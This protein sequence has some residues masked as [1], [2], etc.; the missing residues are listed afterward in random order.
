MAKM[1]IFSLILLIIS[2]FFFSLS[3]SQ[4]V[5]LNC[6]LRK[7][8]GTIKLVELDEY[9]P[10]LQSHTLSQ[11]SGVMTF[12]TKTPIEGITSSNF[13]NNGS[14][15]KWSYEAIV[16]SLTSSD[17]GILTY[18]FNPKNGRTSLSITTQGVLVLGPLKGFC[19]KN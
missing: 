9:T 2:F 16:D 15:W 14:R 5:T 8:A 13:R 10:T 4:A 12:N 11:N 7:T 19:K 18:I 17:T 1:K 3:L 6:E